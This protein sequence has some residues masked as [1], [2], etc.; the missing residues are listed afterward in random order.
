MVCVVFQSET[1]QQLSKFE[2]QNS[3][4]SADFYGNGPG[5]SRRDDYYNTGPDLQDIRDGMKQS[6]TKVAGRL[7]NI[8]NG[9]VSSLQVGTGKRNE[10]WLK[11]LIVS[12]KVDS[13]QWNFSGVDWIKP[14]TKT[15]ERLP[16]KRE[17]EQQCDFRGEI[18]QHAKVVSSEMFHCNEVSRSMTVPFLLITVCCSQVF[19]TF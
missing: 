5:S 4:S 15:L 12:F 13:V 11:W 3:I 8:A 16:L 19:M 18:S 6:V 7:S 17:M 9:I 10:N 2:G 1:R 14:E